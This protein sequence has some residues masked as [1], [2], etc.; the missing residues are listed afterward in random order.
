M[1]LC[2]T[3]PPLEN[4]KSE[5]GVCYIKLIVTHRKNVLKCID[6]RLLHKSRIFSVLVKRAQIAFG[7]RKEVTNERHLVS[8]H[9]S[10]VC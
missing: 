8:P 2:W 4:G 6:T 7:M 9:F 3:G 10:H 5:Q 1:A